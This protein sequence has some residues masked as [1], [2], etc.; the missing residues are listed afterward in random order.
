MD[1][2]PNWF[3]SFGPNGA[4]ASAGS[5]ALILEKQVD[6]AVKATA[7]LQRERLKSME[8]KKEAVADFDEYLEVRSVRKV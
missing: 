4:P 1:G 7:K 6:Y 3:Q 2:F 8:V 5:L